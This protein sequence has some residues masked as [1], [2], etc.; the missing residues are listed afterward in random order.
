MKRFVSFALTIIFFLILVDKGA[1]LILDHFYSKM[2]TGQTGGKINYYLSLKDSIDL[3]VMGNS[4][5]LYQI[6]PDSFN[7]PAFNLSH[8]GM[9]QSFQT[10]LLSVLEE[11]KK[12]P[13]IIALHIEPQEFTGVTHNLDIQNLKYYYGKD[14][15]VTAYIS[16]LSHFEKLKFTFGL[17]RYNGRLITLSKNYLQTLLYG[18]SGNGYEAITH[19]ERDSV[20]TLYSSKKQLDHLEEKFN[21]DQLGY[22]M[23]FINICK[24]NDVTLICFTS[25]HFRGEHQY[26]RSS[27]TLDSLL[28]RNSIAYVNYTEHAIAPLDLNASLWKDAHHL[29][30]SGATI[31]SGLLAQAVRTILENSPHH[32][33]K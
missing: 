27:H 17:Y 24:R 33:L 31:E 19:S 16:Q 30:H 6:I 13:E 1:V 20:N 8:A 32:K 26:A 2:K 12:L 5:A 23:T 4:R 18:A 22:L 21:Y 10:G 14:S 28:Q 7:M 11:N 9:S 3:L 25:P 15:I 29:N